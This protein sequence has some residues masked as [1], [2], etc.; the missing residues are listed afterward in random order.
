VNGN[1]NVKCFIGDNC[2][3]NKK[4]ASNMG[5]PLVGCYSHRFNLG[6]KKC[7]REWPGLEDAVNSIKNVMKK[8]RNLKMPRCSV[9]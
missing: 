6:V 9:K 2:E 1:K 8:A 5:K 3:V 7:M 4:L